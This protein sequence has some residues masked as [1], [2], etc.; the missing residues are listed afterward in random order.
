[1]SIDKVQYFVCGVSAVC[2]VVIVCGGAWG[3]FG[4]C[5]KNGKKEDN[6]KKENKFRWEDKGDGKVEGLSSYVMCNLIETY[7]RDNFFWHEWIRVF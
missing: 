2:S 1:M 4:E 5:N 6:W 3:C 7:L